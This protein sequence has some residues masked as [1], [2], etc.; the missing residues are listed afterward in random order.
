MSPDLLRAFLASQSAPNLLCRKK[1]TLEKN[2]EIIAPHFFNFSAT[3]LS[4]DVMTF[5][6]G[7]HRYFSTLN[8]GAKI[9]C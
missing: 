6:F 7:L 8:G 4:A 1:H 9:G 2:V 5:F 3:S